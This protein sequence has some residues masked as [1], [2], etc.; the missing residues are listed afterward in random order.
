MIET[1]GVTILDENGSK[2]Y[3][4][5]TVNSVRERTHRGP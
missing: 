1:L 2:G 4:P 3:K 5:Q